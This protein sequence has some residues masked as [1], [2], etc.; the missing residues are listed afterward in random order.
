MKNFLSALV[1]ISMLFGIWCSQ[2]VAQDGDQGPN[3]SPL[4]IYTCNYLKGKDRGDLDKVIARWNAW[5]DAND[6]A[7][8]NAWVM[9]PA[10]TGP[11]ITFDLAWMGAWPTF[12]DMGKSLQTWQDKGSQMN[13]SFFSVFSC[14]QHSSMGVIPLQAPEGKFPKKSLIRFSDC[15]VAEGKSSSDALAAH[16]KMISFMNADGQNTA[17]YVFFPGMGAGDI[18][19]DYKLVLA[20]PDYPSLAKDGEKF[21]NGGGWMEAGK[22]MDGVTSCDSFRLYQ[23]DLVRDGSAN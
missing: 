1:T 16:R 11:D 20:N 8:Y 14:D 2:A 23:A 7:P 9:T 15:T 13:A 6:P 4:E 10:F 19:F 22:L 5:T 12:A 17:A 18:D 3:V 21:T